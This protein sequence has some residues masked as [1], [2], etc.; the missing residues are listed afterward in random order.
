MFHFTAV[1]YPYMD[2]GKI[3]VMEDGRALA[4]VGI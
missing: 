4:A 2:E 3:S 1:N